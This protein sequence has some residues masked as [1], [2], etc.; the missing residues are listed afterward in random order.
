MIR[1]E[2]T[3]WENDKTPVNAQHLG[4]VED[5]LEYLFDVVKDV[6]AGEDSRI[7]NEK[8]RQVNETT[9]QNN[10]IK[11]NDTLNAKAKEVD[12]AIV[13]SNNNIKEINNKF[14]TI[15]ASKQQDAEVILAR[16]KYPSLPTRLDNLDKDLLNVKDTAIIPITTESNFT[17][18]EETSN[19]YLTDVKL[20]G[21]TLVN[22]TNGELPKQGSCD[23]ES[24]IATTTQ[25]EMKVTRAGSCVLTR[26][27]IFKRNTDYT[28]IV[29]VK[30][31]SDINDLAFSFH[32]AKTNSFTI[33]IKTIK[34]L[35]NVDYATYVIKLNTDNYEDIDSL[36]IGCHGSLPVNSILGV[37]DVLVLEGD[38]TQNPPSYFE[39]MKSVGDGVDEIVVSSVKGDGNLFIPNLKQGYIGQSSGEYVPGSGDSN[40]S[41][42]IFIKVT[43]NKKYY[44]NIELKT[45]KI[46]NT[47]I[48]K[49]DKHKNYLGSEL[50]GNMAM[51]VSYITPSNTEFVKFRFDKTK[52]DTCLVSDFNERIYFGIQ[53][54]DYI[55]HKSD[56]KKVLY[57]D[58]ESQTLK[59]PILREWDSI[60]KHSDG[61]YY[62][63][64]RSDIVTLNGNEVRISIVGSSHVETTIYRIEDYSNKFANFKENELA[65]IICNKL[66]VYSHSH[67]Y[68]TDVE[69]VS[70]IISNIYISSK[71][72]NNITA[73]KESLRVNPV[74]I[75]YQLAKEEVYE[76]TP[77][78][79]IAYKNET[80]YMIECGAV[81][82]KS[83]FKYEGNIGN[84][85]N[86]LKEK[87]S[88]LEEKLYKT[89][90]ANF[91]VALNAL[92]TKL[93]LE[94]L[95]K[96]PR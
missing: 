67:L 12:N 94:Q 28:V 51:N 89:N 81:T 56:K 79:L 17:T 49:Y 50:I 55:P 39:G 14:E 1:Y 73:F 69:G 60:E 32:D 72:K 74:T 24:I 52:E 66:P 64:K 65:K 20:E 59:K 9:R 33:G 48:F 83:S 11:R 63:H 31:I 38:Y 76:C 2:K 93:K 91:T 6:P 25:R 22:I 54:I 13:A 85:I 78:D 42:D 46:F 84:V 95:T 80:N 82:P 61:K 71:I 19:G 92:D 87:V 21:K 62:Y 23:V 40:V 15:V 88:Y 70:S 58:T 37:K 96:T 36:A 90:L 10:E 29:K 4:K 8:Q 7:A 47:T 30:Y 3:I 68:S 5:G 75:V 77:I 43:P 26:K 41:N 18:V 16:G 57:Y 35:N 27:G 34:K 86:T 44:L 53:N 45:N